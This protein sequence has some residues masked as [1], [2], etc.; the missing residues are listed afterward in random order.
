MHSCYNIWLQKVQEGWYEK[1]HEW[2][3]ALTAYETKQE[4]NPEDFSLTI[5]RMRCLE[6]LAEW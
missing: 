3:K 6:A 2:N 5:G 1:L 4:K